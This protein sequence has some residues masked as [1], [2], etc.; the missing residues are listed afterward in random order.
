M[1]IYDF[2]IPFKLQLSSFTLDTRGLLSSLFFIRRLQVMQEFFHMCTQ[3]AAAVQ[4]LEGGNS[5]DDEQLSRP[6]KRFI[7]DYVRKQVC[8]SIVKYYFAVF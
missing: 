6:V 3:F 2:C 7:A 8:T 4:G 1:Y 5:Y